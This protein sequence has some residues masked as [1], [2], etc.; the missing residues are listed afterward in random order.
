MNTLDELLDSIHPAQTI[1]P[2]E[3]DVFS[4]LEQPK[5]GVLVIDDFGELEA[6]LTRFVQLARNAICHVPPEIGAHT[7]INL[8]EALQ[9]LQGFGY[10]H[11]QAIGTQASTGSGGG[12]RTILQKLGEGM[13]KEYVEMLAGEWAEAWLLHKAVSRS[14]PKD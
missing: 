12:L 11:L 5:F 1:D 8:S 13:V 6:Y 7:G 14:A 3:H 4:V 2:I 9:R 10:P